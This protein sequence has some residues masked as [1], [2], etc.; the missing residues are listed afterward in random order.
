MPTGQSPI[1]VE[2]DADR[3]I[4]SGACARAASTVFAQD[5]TGV[6]VLLDASPPALFRSA[7]EDAASACPA[8]VIT[9]AEG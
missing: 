7:V 4:G 6:V 3:C 1:R 2:I 5:E 8:Q 9:W